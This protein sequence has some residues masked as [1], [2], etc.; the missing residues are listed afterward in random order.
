MKE[1]IKKHLIKMVSVSCYDYDK[2][3][4]ENLKYFEY[5]KQPKRIAD[6]IARTI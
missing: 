3:I 5:L 1:K 4:E 6:A 2:I